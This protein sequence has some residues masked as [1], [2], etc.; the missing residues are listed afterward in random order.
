MH[1]TW[2]SPAG[3]HVNTEQ[4]SKLKQLNKHGQKQNYLALKMPK[5]NKVEVSVQDTLPSEPV[6]VNQLPRSLHNC[7]NK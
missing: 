6:P 5:S 3:R 2:T 7:R 1:V 4:S